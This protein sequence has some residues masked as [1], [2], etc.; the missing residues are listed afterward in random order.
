MTTMTR[1]FMLMILGAVMVSGVDTF[2]KGPR[3]IL[4]GVLTAAPGIPATAIG[5]AKY[6]ASASRTNFT[7]E[8]QGLTTLNGR[9][10][11]IFVNGKNIGSTRI[12][13]GRLKFELSTERGQAVPPVNAG[14]VVEVHILGQRILAGSVR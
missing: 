2:A 9:S 13:L 11:A 6:D 4:T 3:T 14:A 5:K 10:A 7:V 12:A 1:F 8:A